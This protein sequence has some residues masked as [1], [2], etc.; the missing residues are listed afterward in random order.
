MTAAWISGIAFHLPENAI[1]NSAL[2]REFPGWS[3]EKIEAKTGIRCRRI[4]AQS[5]SASDLAVR[6][7]EKLLAKMDRAS[8]D[9]L[10]FCTQTPDQPLPTTACTI[11]Q[12]LGLASACGAL[13]FN[14]G[15]SGYIYGLGLAQGLLASD[16]AKRVLLL[17]GDTYNQFIDPSDR[18]LRVLFGDGAAATLIERSDGGEPW[19]FVY[20]TD[21]G[22]AR[23]L[24]V[25]AGGRRLPASGMAVPRLVMNG[26]EIFTFT[27]RTIPTLVETLLAK[28]RLK[29]DEIDLFVF[30]QANQFMLEHLR[31]H[32]AI[33]Q[34]RFVVNMGDCGNTVSSSIPI[35]LSLAAERLRPGMRIMLV[36]FGVGYSWGGTVL[37]WHP[38]AQ[39]IPCEAYP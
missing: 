11:Q 22:G 23:N 18:G 19:R 24:M 2:A 3:E 16:Q 12:R 14:L 39:L 25:E 38:D 37:T 31:A 27:L 29:L 21:G 33:P 9:Y 1:T 13:D 20:G 5:E 17:T 26:S 36:G 8:I 7:A 34:E 35:A 6:A 30:H 10:L 32:L 15:C 28:T 4:A